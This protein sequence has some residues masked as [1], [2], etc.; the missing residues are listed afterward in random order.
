MNH[1]HRQPKW[2]L[3]LWQWRCQRLA[4]WSWRVIYSQLVL[5]NGI[6]IQKKL[7]CVWLCECVVQ[8]DSTQFTIP[9]SRLL[10]MRYLRKLTLN[11]HGFIRDCYKLAVRSEEKKTI[12][13]RFMEC[14]QTWR[15]QTKIHK[16][17]YTIPAFYILYYII[18]TYFFGN[19]KNRRWR[20]KRAQTSWLPFYSFLF[21]FA[22]LLASGGVEI[23]VAGEGEAAERTICLIATCSI[24]HHLT[25]GR[26]YLRI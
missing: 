1:H 2:I 19:K 24:G 9:H 5:L 13:R 3:C 20:K 11:A 14:N 16:E 6:Y 21:V 12:K 23:V 18:F 15:Q 17:K 25:L 10:C 7:S 22:M 26:C 8:Q 4:L